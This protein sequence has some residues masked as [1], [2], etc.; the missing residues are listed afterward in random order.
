[1]AAA[2][3]VGGAVIVAVAGFWP[4]HGVPARPSRLPA[5]HRLW[6]KRAAVY[7]D[8]LAAMN[9]RQTKRRYDAQLLPR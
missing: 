5:R 2:I 3:G 1:M 8:T 6:D 7:V 9:F 4:P